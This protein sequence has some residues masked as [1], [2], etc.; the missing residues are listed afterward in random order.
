MREYKFTFD[1]AQKL[2]LDH[3]EGKSVKELTLIYN[4]CASNVRKIIH[5]RTWKK[6]NKDGNDTK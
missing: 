3:K 4:T 1:L 2:R 5:F 6:N